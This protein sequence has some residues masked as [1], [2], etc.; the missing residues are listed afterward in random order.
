[1]KR[2]FLVAVVCG[3][4]L[5]A[6][7]LPVRQVILYKHG[8]GFF[9]R[10]G[11]LSAGESARLD[12]RPS[13]VNDVLKSLTIQEKGG[14]KI[15]G[16]RYDSDIPLAEKLKDFPF[17]LGDGQSLTAVLDQL[18]GSRVEMQFGAERVSGVIV[19]ARMTPGDRER[20]EREQVTLLLDNGDLRN[21]DLAAAATLRFSDGKLQSQFKDYLAAVTAS[22]STDR[23]SV[24]VDST[25]AKSRD[26]VASYMIPTP[27][28][29][30]S[31]RLILDS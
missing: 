8:V 19:A 9:E 7:E 27:I 1:M 17:R 29:K 14:G 2:S 26:V 24:Y 20:A 13:E 4:D 3:F 28:W 25:D 16:V 21:F 23:R 10:L 5:V 15:S 31:Y 12:F 18:K 22:R 30:S 11:T 6:A